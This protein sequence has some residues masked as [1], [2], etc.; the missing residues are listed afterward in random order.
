L[1]SSAVEKPAYWRMVQGRTAYIVACGPRMKGSK[2]GSVSACGRPAVSAAV[3][4]G[5]TVMPSGVV[6]FSAATSPPGADLAAAL[7]LLERGWS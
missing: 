1:L 4:S 2:P 5:L 7:P 3:Y 6:Q